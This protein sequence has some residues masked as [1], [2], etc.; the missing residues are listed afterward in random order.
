[1]VALEWVSACFVLFFFFSVF[2]LFLVVFKFWSWLH[3]L[4][5]KIRNQ[6]NLQVAIPGV[7]NTKWQ[8]KKNLIESEEKAVQG[9][10]GSLGI[11]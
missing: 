7:K 1:M 2:P 4:K 11:N 3:F 9:E 6:L 8:E 10:E 5:Y